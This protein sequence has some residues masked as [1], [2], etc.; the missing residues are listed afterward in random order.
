MFNAVRGRARPLYWAA[1]RYPFSSDYLFR[2]V[3]CIVLRSA[4]PYSLAG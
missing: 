2:P 4:C 3:A 1:E